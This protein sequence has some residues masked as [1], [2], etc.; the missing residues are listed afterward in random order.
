MHSI[1]CKQVTKPDPYSR[2]RNRDSYFSVEPCQCPT[3]IKTHGRKCT[4]VQPSSEIKSAML[5]FCSFFFVEIFFFLIV[6]VILLVAK[7]KSEKCGK[8]EEENIAYQVSFFPEIPRVNFY[9]YTHTFSEIKINSS[10][11]CCFFP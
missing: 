9:V 2:D 5:G 3:V 8:Y 1:R 4:S 7:K 6:K 10:C 11:T